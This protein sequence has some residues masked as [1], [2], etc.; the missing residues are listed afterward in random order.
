[1]PKKP[2][3]D[4]NLICGM[5]PEYIRKKFFN[6]EIG[7]LLTEIQSENKIEE[8]DLDRL[9]SFMTELKGEDKSVVDKIMLAFPDAKIVDDSEV[10]PQSVEELM[11]GVSDK[12]WRTKADQAIIFITNT[13]E[14]IRHAVANKQKIADNFWLDT[15]VVFLSY[16]EILEKDRVYKTQKYYARITDI[17]DTIGCSRLEAENR[18]KL[19]PDYADYKYITLL[20]ERMDKF[21]MLAKKKDNENKKW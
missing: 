3:D 10:K 16:Q 21:D 14:K 2:T 6:R 15:A 7:Q 9:I 12:E 1:M 19:T 13:L 5:T 8:A 17:I 18:A 11:K 20:L 4:K